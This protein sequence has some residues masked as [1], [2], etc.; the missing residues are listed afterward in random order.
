MP[1]ETDPLWANERELRRRAYLAAGG[2][3]ADF[4]GSYWPETRRRL[5]AERAEASLKRGRD[6]RYQL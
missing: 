4:D 5:V 6:A 2:S 1:D 3:E